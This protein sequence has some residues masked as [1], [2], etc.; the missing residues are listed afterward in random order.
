MK[1]QDYDFFQEHGYLPLGKI[2]SAEELAYYT[3]I[4]DRD[5]AEE[6]ERWYPAPDH[7][8]INCDALFSSPGD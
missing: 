2:L 6:Q 7:Q 1:K 8:M 3:A 5:W 4:F